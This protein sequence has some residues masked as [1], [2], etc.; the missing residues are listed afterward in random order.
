MTQSTPLQLVWLDANIHHGINREFWISVCDMYPDA[1]RFDNPDECLQFLGSGV[2][3]PRR[4]VFI[5]S[6]VFAEKLVPDLQKH[7]NILS[8]YVYCAHISKHEDWSRQFEKV[9]HSCYVDI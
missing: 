6:G 1:K 7:E 2:N 9:K 8:I 5:V 4:F 3:D